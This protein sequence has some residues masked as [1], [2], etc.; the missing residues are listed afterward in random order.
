[1][2]LFGFFAVFGCC[3]WFVLLSWCFCLWVGFCLSVVILG[4]LFVVCRFCG[5]ISLCGFALVVW[6]GLFG[7]LGCVCFCG[8]LFWGVLFCLRVCC[9]SLRCFDV[10]FILCFLVISFGYRRVCLFGGLQVACFLGL[11]LWLLVVWMYLFDLLLWFS[12]ACF[13]GFYLLFYVCLYL[14]CVCFGGWFGASWR[15]GCCLGVRLVD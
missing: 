13:V 8:V 10:C 1:M 12:F 6:W 7:V 15:F 3:L 2:G 9:C 5:V 14:L 4:T 11:V